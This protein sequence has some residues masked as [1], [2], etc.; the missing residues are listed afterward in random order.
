[1][2]EVAWPPKDIT[3]PT[4]SAENGVLSVTG[5]GKINAPASF[6][7][8]ILLDTST[9]P[10]WCT[11]VPRVSITEQPASATRPANTESGDASPIIQRGTKLTLHAVMGSPG[12]KESPSHMIVSDLSTPSMPSSYI[13]PATLGASPVY[14]AD[15]SQVYR[16]A[17]KGDKIDFIGKNMNVERFNEVIIKGEEQCEIHSWE[18]MGGVLAYPVKW[19]YQKTLIKKFDEWCTGLKA[20]A[21]KQWEERQRQEGGVR[22]SEP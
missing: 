13:S 8:D 18:V 21:E 5:S 22:A 14:T 2:A 19:L 11:L 16:V 20:H 7:F 10:K 1:M 9:Y 3:T 4:V 15:L 12:S 17:W 6:V